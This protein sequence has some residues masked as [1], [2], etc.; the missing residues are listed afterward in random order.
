M[1]V[2]RGSGLGATR[3][4]TKEDVVPRSKRIPELRTSEG[5]GVKHEVTT[6]RL[7]VVRCG[8]CSQKM[9][10]QPKKTTGQEVL[11]AHCKK[12]HGIG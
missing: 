3:A 1:T 11:A 7:P 2:V 4:C 12:V 9:A 5:R 8:I 6:G 10:Y